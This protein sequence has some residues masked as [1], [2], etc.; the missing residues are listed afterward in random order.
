MQ[1]LIAYITV[2]RHWIKLCQCR[3][4]KHWTREDLH[5]KYIVTL[6]GMVASPFVSLHRKG[7]FKVSCFKFFLALKKFC[8]HIWFMTFRGMSFA[9]KSL[10]ILFL[11]FVWVKRLWRDLLTFK[12]L[13]NSSNWGE[14]WPM[15][16]HKAGWRVG[17]RVCKARGGV[18][19]SSLG[20][21]LCVLFSNQHT[22]HRIAPVSSRVGWL[23]ADRH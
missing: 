16:Q 12:Y 21:G 6:F 2:N 14:S 23:S 10:F 9:L 11:N 19:S 4:L 3:R 17:G 13:A 1:I 22:L 18:L 8:P 15:T 5:C 20:T 7:Y